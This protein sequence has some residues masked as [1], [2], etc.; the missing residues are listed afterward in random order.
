MQPTL[1]WL[2][3][4]A[5]DRDRMRRVLD[6]F[7]E[8]GTVDEL[9][10]GTLRDHI[11]DALFPGTSSIQTRLRYA[12]FIPWLYQELE[13][14]RVSAADIRDRARAAELALI[15][16]LLRS[17]DADG[18]I[19]SSARGKLRRLPSEA[20]WAG[21]VRWGLFVPGKS[22]GW[23]QR[24]FASLSRKSAP[25]AHPDDPGVIWTTQ[26]SWSARLPKPPSEF[27]TVASLALTNEEAEFLR[28]QFTARV[29]GS[30][31]QWLATEG[32]LPAPGGAFWDESA[33]STAPQGVRAV[34]E[35][36][37]RFSLH[38]EGAPLLYNL[39]LADARH[40]LKQEDRDLERTEELR[41][42][43]GVWAAQEAVEDP[44]DPQALWAFVA[45]RGGRVAAQ[46]LRFVETWSARTVAVGAAAVLDDPEARRLIQH[47]EQ[48][49][50]TTRSR[51]LSQGRL[52]AWTAPVGVGRMDFRWF[53]VR[54][55][56][57]DLHRGLG[58]T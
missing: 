28:D 35:L 29:P 14:K 20:Y 11:S 19:G 2:D 21:L 37:R 41:G 33:I 15:D 9:G 50:K 5:D 23:Y 43:L 4:T 48:Q 46:Q 24:H 16:P 44:F 27:P 31:L 22:Q 10:L 6:L 18:V 57:I 58:V 26:R 55:L 49:L 36:A 54:Q 38:V 1:T 8:Q 25:S 40:A 13:R 52:S 51:F 39:M 53:R 42:R 17:D 12:L 34:T 47:R 32:D 3:L 56:L 45:M 30:L 7:S